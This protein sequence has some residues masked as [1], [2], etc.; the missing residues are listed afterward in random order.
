MKIKWI[1]YWLAIIIMIFAS[2][3]IVNKME[4]LAIYNAL[5]VIA[6]LILAIFWQL[7]EG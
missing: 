3:D 5:F 2:I 6:N 7:E 4:L 1:H